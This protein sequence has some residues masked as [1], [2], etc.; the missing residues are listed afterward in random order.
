MLPLIFQKP[1]INSVLI[2][3]III[4][5]FVIWFYHKQKVS[6][7]TI[8]YSLKSDTKTGKT[9]LDYNLNSEGI[10]IS[11]TLDQLVLNLDGKLITIDKKRWVNNMKVF[12]TG[13]RFF[14]I[15]TKSVSTNYVFEALMKYAMSKIDTRIQ[16]LNDIKHQ[17]QKELNSLKL[18]AA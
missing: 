12:D 13:K 10:V 5:T 14:I 8:L 16:F 6:L 15:C 1:L 11:N 9:I 3:G 4:V 17:Y 7:R 18:K 2:C